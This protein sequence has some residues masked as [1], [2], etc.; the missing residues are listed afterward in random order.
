M[1]RADPSIG[2][3]VV[4]IEPEVAMGLAAPAGAPAA[5]LSTALGGL[6]TL[7]TAGGGAGTLVLIVI[8]LRW[9]SVSLTGRPEGVD[10][11]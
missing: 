2:S 10:P 5:G 7:G 11:A 8:R 1:R 6:P 9:L 3:V 4:L